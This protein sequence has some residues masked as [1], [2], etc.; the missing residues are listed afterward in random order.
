MHNNIPLFIRLHR[1]KE[2]M[3]NVKTINSVEQF[4]DNLTRIYL[5]H[6]NDPLYVDES[7]EEIKKKLQNAIWIV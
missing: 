7:Y 6:C 5:N 2:L 3:V 4:D 1:G